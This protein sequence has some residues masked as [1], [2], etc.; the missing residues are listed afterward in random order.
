M[1]KNT[2]KFGLIALLFSLIATS[3]SAQ[4]VQKIGNNQMSISPSAVLELESTTKGFLLPRMTQTQR[5]A[6]ASPAMGLVVFQ[7][8]GVKGLY[9]YI[10][11]GW[12]ISATADAMQAALDSK[13]STTDL[14]DG[15]ALKEDTANRSNN[16]NS[17]ASSV[18]KYP[19]VKAV[20]DYVAANTLSGPQG[21][22]GEKGDKGDQG[23]AGT[24]GAD[25]AVGAKGDTGA[26]GIQGEKGDKG[27]QGVAGTNGI[28][29]AVGAKGDTGATGP[30][31]S[32]TGFV[33]V[34]GGI[35]GTPGALSGDVTSSGL[36]TTLANS[37]V[38]A[39]TYSKVTVD[40]K[41]RVTAGANLVAGDIPTLNQDTTGNA[42]T[43]TT[44]ANLTGAITS[45]GNATSLG[46]FSSSNMATALT[47]E[48][49][50]GK[51]VFSDSP[52]LVTPI[53]GE[54]ASGVATNLTGLPLTTGVTGILPVANG[55]TNSTATPTNG[56]VGYG[57]GTAHAYS[58]AGTNGEI[59]QSSGAGTPVWVSG[60]TMMFTGNTN[61][62]AASTANTTFYPVMGTISGTAVTTSSSAGTRTLISRDGTIRNLY[63]KSSTNPGS[64]NSYA[65]SIRLNGSS[66]TLTA[67][68]SGSN[69]TS[70]SNTTN[71]F[72]VVAGDEIEIQLA[73]NSNPTAAKISWAVD[74]T[75]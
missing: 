43:V 41:G 66:T 60:G 28:D 51:L 65:I 45:V 53:L 63:V 25:G 13:A 8:D 73:P 48:T 55:G 34:S 30:A 4:V 32:G 61:N 72:T 23:V 38:T 24:N 35:L 75:Y 6:I 27:D 69:A 18:T 31:P 26:Q 37:G 62:V 14:T 71:S 40:A 54:P 46:S 56:G 57:T 2:L 22:Q 39:G 11:S 12:I 16:V 70:A 3:V 42:A 20:V 52:T 29:G 67:T 10:G 58:T 33:T 49:G 5:E 1:Y 19:S 64:G 36:V 9:C 15:L 44:N 7:T 68:I 50:T 47:D 59:L 17:D 74:F 21:I